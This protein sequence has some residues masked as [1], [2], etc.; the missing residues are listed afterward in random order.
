MEK[1]D[2]V[3]QFELPTW[4]GVDDATVWKRKSDAEKREEL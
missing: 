4:W 3:E 2:R 1:F